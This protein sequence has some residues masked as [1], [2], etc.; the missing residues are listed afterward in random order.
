[1]THHFLKVTE[2][3]DSVSS[4]NQSV[5]HTSAKSILDFQ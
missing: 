1:M 3:L 5:D 2:N 4:L